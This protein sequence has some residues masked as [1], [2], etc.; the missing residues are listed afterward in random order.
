MGE[1][2]SKAFI[3]IYIL[4][5]LSTNASHSSYQYH[6]PGFQP[7]RVDG[8]SKAFLLGHMNPLEPLPDKIVLAILLFPLLGFQQQ[9]Y[10]L[11]ILISVVVSSFPCLSAHRCVAQQEGEK[12]LRRVP[13]IDLVMGPQYANRLGDLLEDVM[14]GNQVR[15]SPSQLQPSIVFCLVSACDIIGGPNKRGELNIMGFCRTCVFLQPRVGGFSVTRRICLP[16]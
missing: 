1:G 8:G 12:L 6:I 4:L 10:H 9:F 15:A 14:N 3:L 13:E 7:R 16:P 2:A 11:N 5:S